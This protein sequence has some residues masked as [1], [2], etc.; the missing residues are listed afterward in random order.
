M[1]ILLKK[2]FQSNVNIEVIDG[3]LDI[4]APVGVITED[5]L[6]EIKFYKKDLIDF[7][8]RYKGDSEYTA[9]PKAPESESY[10][11]TDSQRRLWIMSQLEGGSLAYNMPGAVT[12]K[13]V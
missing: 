13:G 10:P 3:K 5:I 6:N 7:F 8:S 4:K 12:L 11:L 9:I 1:Q 2:L